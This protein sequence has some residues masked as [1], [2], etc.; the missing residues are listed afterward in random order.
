LLFI[1]A[2]F[3]SHDHFSPFIIMAVKDL[4]KKFARETS[5]GKFIPQVDGLRFVA[6][7]LVVLFHLNAYVA[8][9]LPVTFST[10]PDQDR[11]SQFL[12]Q[13]HYGVQLFFII[14]G[15]ILAL[16][17]ASHR[18]VQAP[19]VKLRAY[20]LRRLTRLE[21]PYLLSLLLISGFLVLRQGE[22]VRTLAPHL[23]AGLVYLHGLT[24]GLPNPINN[25]AWSLE[26]EVQFYLLVPLL[27][28]L[29]AIANR[30]QRRAVLIGLGLAAITFQRIFIH[31][32]DGRLA[33]SLPNFL[34]FFLVGFLLADLYLCEWREDTRR[35]R[36]WDV[37]A[38]AGCL[39]LPL[40]WSHSLLLSFAFPIVAFLHYGAAFRGPLTYRVLGNRWLVTIGG[41][42]YTIYLL[43]YPLVNFT[44]A[45]SKFLVLTNN[46]AVNLLAQ[47]LMIGPVILATSAVFFL[48]IEK[49]CMKKDW[50][51]R[52]WRKLR[53]GLSSPAPTPPQP[54]KASE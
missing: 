35:R 4:L 26:V 32:S 39:T 42:C 46:F 54:A 24:Y 28:G 9:S 50:P 12:A 11:L 52:L 5:T 37:I 38:L 41:M 18:L 27:T 19:R 8:A 33:L 30:L 31:G 45:R 6:I 14:S 7:S 13:G 34:Q 49:P 17:F 25:V 22:E 44:F 21:P 40:I 48:V 23:G 15:F 16:P 47:F 29:F 43:H 2:T 36:H 20:Y 3:A 51:Q 53:I 1:A 10:A